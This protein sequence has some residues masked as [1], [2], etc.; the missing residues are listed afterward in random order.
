M[1]GRYCIEIDEE[2]LREIV[3]EA[4]KNIREKEI[5]T[6]EIYPT[7]TAPVITF[8]GDK[9]KPEAMEWGFPN[10]RSKSGVIINA[11]AETVL[12]KRTF[13]DAVLNRRCIIP[14][15]GFYEW[16]DVG[17][18]KKDKYLFTLPSSNILYMAGL[19]SIYDGVKKFVI[20]TTS[21]NDSMQDIHNRMP[22]VLQSNAIDNWVLDTNAALEILQTVPPDLNKAIV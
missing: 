15:T 4:E 2:E 10:F 16:K 20:I 7:N 6:G 17:T 11:R 13:R 3:N 21:A 22:I 8:D 12:E 18:K 14:A 1:C 5:K 19:Y 9:P